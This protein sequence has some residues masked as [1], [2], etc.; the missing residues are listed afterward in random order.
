MAAI[1]L[2]IC[3][4]TYNRVE[5]VTNCVRRIVSE[6]KSD[7]IEILVGDNASTDGTEEEIAKIKDSRL[8]YYKNKS[9]LGIAGNLLKIIK[10]ANGDFIY[11]HWDDDLME[12][13]TIP[14]ILET[15][16]KNQSLNQILGKID[17]G[18]GNIYWS[19]EKVCK[20]CEDKLLKPCF[21]SWEMLFFSYDHGGARI[22]RK[23]S[24]N[25]EYAEKF[26]KRPISPYIH[27]VLAIFPVLTG[28]TLCTSKI[29]YHIESISRDS[30]GHRVKGVPY[31]HSLSKLNRRIDRI[32]IINDIT[33]EI[34][35][36]IPVSENFDRLELGRFRKNLLNKQRKKIAGELVNLLYNSFGLFLETLPRILKSRDISKSYTFWKY[37][38]KAFL[39]CTLYRVS[40]KLKSG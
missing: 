21:K 20:D 14:W 27:Q 35:F 40:I 16:K 22:F 23:D 25:L 28:A 10:E 36:Q 11:I 3:I 31:W 19:C 1:S 6:C 33:N 30:S 12:L 24:I 37:L 9:N 34:V 7:E 18:A 38:L 39:G 26:L 17:R 2:T 13:S 4:P 5:R 15:I 32:K 29:I 8:R